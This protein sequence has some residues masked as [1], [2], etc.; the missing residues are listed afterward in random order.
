MAIGDRMR[1]AISNA[2][3]A[4]NSVTSSVSSVI[5]S[6][7]SFSGG[8]RSTSL[9]PKTETI[10]TY[11]LWI[12]LQGLE[13]NPKRG[14][15]STYYEY[16]DYRENN[17]PIRKLTVN[18]PVGDL[19]TIKAMEK[20]E[21]NGFG[22]MYRL[23][24]TIM[25]MA[26]EG[27]M[28]RPFVDGVFLA[29]LI[30]SEAPVSA[31]VVDN[32]TSIIFEDGPGQTTTVSFTLYFDNEIV[33][34][35]GQ[36][37]NRVYPNPTLHE[38]FC[39]V[40]NTTNPGLPYIQSDFDYNPSIG[41]YVLTPRSFTGTI[42]EMEQE[43]GFY[44]TDYMLFL[45]HGVLFFLNTEDAP[46]A[47]FPSFENHIHV[48]VTRPADNNSLMTGIIMMDNNNCGF[49]VPEIYVSVNKDN[50][51]TFEP[52]VHHI[53]PSGEIKEEEPGLRRGQVVVQKQTEVAHI[54][55]MMSIQYETITVQNPW[56]SIDFLTPLS[57]IYYLGSDGFKRSY[58]LCSKELTVSSA[59]VVSL[60]IQGFRIVQPGE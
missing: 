57:R 16:C 17:F 53:T 33:F 39:D 48:I 4:I 47:E 14:Y 50:P 60:T 7:G 32:P 52:K 40:L 42:R 28:I 49:N 30:D 2:S 56:M 3:S 25:A 46:N 29:Q 12:D 27:S 34:D 44:K 45:E 23:R 11:A 9:N 38:I 26:T 20:E 35:A 6:L 31:E 24:I 5:S 43:I 36:I 41:R 58:R 1:S 51:G 10:Q 18:I 19:L 22:E 59:G 15:S 37:S 21:I 54:E 13:M 55:K 8:N